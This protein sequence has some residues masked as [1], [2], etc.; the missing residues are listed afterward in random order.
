MEKRLFDLAIAIPSAM[1]V[2]PIILVLSIL[3]RIQSRGPAI[4][5]Q[6]RV[7]R[8]QKIFTCYKLRTM[9]FGTKDLPS[10]QVSGGAITSIGRILRK[11]KLDELPQLY[12]IICGEMSFVGP[13][14]C[15]PSQADLI[16]ERAARGLFT[17]RPGVTGLAQINNVDMSTPGKL[18]TID[19]EYLT[20]ASF[21]LDLK[22]IALTV[23][24]SGL[25]VDAAAK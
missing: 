2:L 4:F 19:A 14:P 1:F 23:L 11:T 22:I 16:S 24:G 12:N 20:N 25:S 13:R 6:K 15:L 8:D 10:H 9:A 5:T 18:A 3:I 21:C 7:G 17:L